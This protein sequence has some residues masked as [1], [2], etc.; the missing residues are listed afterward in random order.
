MRRDPSNG[1]GTLRNAWVREFR[2]VLDS[3][4][5]GLAFNATIRVEWRRHESEPGR[6]TSYEDVGRA[7]RGVAEELAA[8]RSVLRA[9]ATEQDINHELRSRNPRLVEGIEILAAHVSLHVDEHTRTSAERMAQLRREETLAEIARRQTTA[10]IR[11]MQD[12]ILRTPATARLYLMLEQ[13]AHHGFLPPGVDADQIV[14]DVQ[15]WHP[16]AKWV[17][18]AQLLHTFLSNLTPKD[19][20]DLLHTLRLL[21]LEYG[22]K[23]LAEQLP[24]DMGGSDH[25][26]PA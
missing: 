3:N 18:V 2:D 13:T 6:T 26:R 14:R 23:E 1:M 7:V 10:R 22:E 12:E 24:A 16:E 20:N 19:G 5:H 9:E 4:E 15:Q 25:E 8:R 11:F 21:F 17:V